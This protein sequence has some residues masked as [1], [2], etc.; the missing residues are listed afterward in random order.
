MTT[1]TKEKKE[2]KSIGQSLIGKPCIVR[3]NVAGVHAGLV[4]EIQGTTVV[5]KDAYRLWRFYTREKTGS[6][7]DI[8]ANGLKPDAQ[9]MIGAKLKTVLI[10]N[11]QGLEVAEMTKDAYKSLTEWENK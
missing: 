6:I 8:A 3:S 11:P 9:H 2:M 10:E 4:E 7:S 1:K 5:L